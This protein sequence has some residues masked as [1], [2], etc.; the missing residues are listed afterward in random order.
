MPNAL[1]PMVG[2]NQSPKPGDKVD[3]LFRMSP[4]PG[5]DAETVPSL[6]A[7]TWSPNSDPHR[8]I[9][10]L[11]G[12]QAALPAMPVI[13]MSTTSGHNLPPGVTW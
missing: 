7:P 8:T 13:A 9:R 2:L 5:M 3:P 4:P 12:N 6:Q 10:R 1:V 11:C